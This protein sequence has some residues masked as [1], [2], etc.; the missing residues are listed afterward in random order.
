VIVA[1]AGII[2]A[3]IAWRLSQR[4]AHV[5]LLDR[6]RFGMEASTAGAGMLAPGGEVGRASFA[7]DL[8]CGSAAMYPS[9]VEELREESGV[10]IDHSRCGAF[11]LALTEAEIEALTARTVTQSKIGIRSEICE[12]RHIPAEL[13]ETSGVAFAF[14]PD[15]AIVDPRQIMAALRVVCERRGVE[16]VEDTAVRA[17][18]SDEKTV[19]VDERQADA[20]VI[21]AGCWSSQIEVP[22]HV[23]PRSYPVRGHLLGYDLPPGSLQHIIRHASIYTLQ[24]STGFTLAGSTMEDVGFDK[25]VDPAIAGHLH[26]CAARLLP[27][28]FTQPATSVWTGLRPASESGLVIERMTGSHVWLSYGHLRNGILAAPATAEIVAEEIISSLGRG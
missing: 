18:R 22:G 27:R 10:T 2:G 6:G 3:S 16:I 13:K 7:A 21:A 1:G 20:A 24:R 12:A 25:T 28:L 9:F 4:G 5:L 23:L 19:R 17:I 14:Y 26:D 11:E 8:F 15:D